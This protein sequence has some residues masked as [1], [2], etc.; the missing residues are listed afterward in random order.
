MAAS[1]TKIEGNKVS[2]TTFNNC[3]KASII[4]YKSE[5]KMERQWL[6]ISA[7]KCAH[8]TRISYLLD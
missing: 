3:G 2:L 5:E 8:G 6:I 7:A 4:G 1:I